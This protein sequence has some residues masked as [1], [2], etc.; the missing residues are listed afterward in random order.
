MILARGSKLCMFPM[1]QTQPSQ[2]NSG[3]EFRSFDGPMEHLRL[4][5][6]HMPVVLAAFDPDGGFLYWNREAE[7]VSGWTFEEL[8]ESSLFPYILPLIYPDQ[9]YL[10]GIMAEWARRGNRYRDWELELT[11]KDGEKR[12]LAFSSVSDLAPIPGW[13][14]WSVGVDVTE[15]V[16]A[17]EAINQLVAGVAHE[18]RNPLF[19]ISATFEAI[20]A[21]LKGRPDLEPHFS[22]LKVEV[23]RLKILLNDLSDLGKPVVLNPQAFELN[24]FLNG[25]VQFASR[26]S[27]EKCP[28]MAVELPPN[29]IQV[30]WDQSRVR[31]ILDNLLHN[32]IQHSP[33]GGEVHVK[34]EVLANGIQVRIR[35]QGPGFAPE[36]L[37]RAFDPFFSR[38]PGGTGLG[39]GIAK[40][41]AEA[42]GGSLHCANAPE[43]GAVLELKLPIIS[44]PEKPHAAP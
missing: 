36:D 8:R 43:G 1:T 23:E 28:R 26:S 15:R 44:E 18:I 17:Q 32:A 6:E 25:A 4:V 7:R 14:S 29:P 12:V 30:F 42:H 38:R 16:R 40:K 37:P 22:V 27:R 35:D 13:T 5:L 34:V 20:Q 10:E 41:F 9:G 24:E 19:G 11:R 3:D 21:S 39:L 2:S 33:D 31:Q